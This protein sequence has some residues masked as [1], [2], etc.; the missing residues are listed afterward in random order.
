MAIPR[1]VK[2]VLKDDIE[3][4]FDTYLW[5]DYH[6]G[7]DFGGDVRLHLV[8][9]LNHKKFGPLV[10]DSFSVDAG[11]DKEEKG[12]LNLV[13][14]T[15]FQVEFSDALVIAVENLGLG[16]RLK[17]KDEDGKFG[18][19]DLDTSISYPTGFGVT[20]DT[21]VAKGGGFISYD[22][23]TCEFFGFFTLDILEKVGVKAYLLC[24]P[25]TAAG[26]FFSLVVLLSATFTPGIPL[27][28]GFSLTAVGGTLGLNRSLN[29][30]AIS[31]GVRTG[32]L[33][34]V[35]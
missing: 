34:Q 27:G 2:E 28:M 20:I 32:T 10:I 14:G 25:G 22:R 11:T 16:F 31:N 1:F 12:K 17:Y 18:D 5:Y 21:S 24:D 33:D 8:Y 4:G 26:H 19:F 6:K 29:R 9:D 13:V 3:L 15:T 23:E 7:F 35:F 30:D